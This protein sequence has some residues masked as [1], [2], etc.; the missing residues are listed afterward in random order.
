[1]EKHNIKVNIRRGDTVVVIAGQDKGKKGK[2]LFVNPEDNSCVVDGVNMIVK[3]KK[4]RGA[5]QKSSRDKRAGNIDISNVQILCKCGKAT[6]I[7]NKIMGDKKVRACKKCGESLDR[8]YQRAKDKI[9]ETEADTKAE[10]KTE[11]KPLKRREVKATAE[12]TVK[13]NS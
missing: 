9:K 4:A 1:M 3:H 7:E 10:E 11:K 13:T 12:S 2:V 6:R 8:K 5:Q